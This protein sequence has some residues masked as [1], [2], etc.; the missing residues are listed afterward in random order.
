MKTSPFTVLS[1]ALVLALGY[2]TSSAESSLSSR[3]TIIVTTDPQPSSSPWSFGVIGD[4]QWTLEKDPAGKNPN[5]VS[6]SIINQINQQ[7]INKGVKFVIQVGDLTENGNDI[8]LEVRAKA[9]QAL[10]KA[11]IGFFPFRGNHETYA[12][13]DGSNG[14][15][16]AAFRS[17]FPQTRC[18]ANTFGATNCNSPSSVSS[19]LEGMSYSFDYGSKGNNARFVI[20]D[21][22]A[23]PSQ[24]IKA[25]KYLYGYSI[26]EQQ[27][28]I[29][30]R[31]DQ[32]SREAA[33]AFV[34][35]HQPPI[36]QNH[37]DSPFH[38]YTNANPEMQNAFIA[39]LQNNGVK[40]LITGHDHIHHRSI[41]AS[42][43]RLSK[44]QEQIIASASSKFYTPKTL[45][46]EKWFGQKMRE[47]SISQEL[48]SPGFY[49]YT[50]NGPRVTVDYYS[51]AAGG[52]KSD[53]AY[54]GTAGSTQGVTPKFNFEKKET[55]GYSLNGKEFLV[56]GNEKTSY[57]VV[58]DNFRNTSAGILSGEY[59]NEVVDYNGRT[60]TQAVT[61]GWTPG[62]TS[63]YSDIFSLW[64]MTPLG[65]NQ[66]S[67]YVLYIKYD[68]KKTHSGSAKAGGVGVA[69]PGSDGK[70][71]NAVAKNIGGTAK[72]VMGPWKPR[73]ELGAYGIDIKTSTAWAIINYNGAFAVAPGI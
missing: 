36:A 19:D 51:D 49:I 41:I 73:H 65:S 52:L 68:R 43:D 71:V 1:V 33:H 37:Q 24:Q 29:N 64:G 50:V 5:G 4:T 15:A 59:S 11:G 48:Y 17:N 53:G 10:Y 47:T 25:A 6:V 12:K 23:T 35:V 18:L 30:Q 26:A 58:Q 42:P 45:S 40:Y 66:T 39:S 8:D 28:W 67:T 46:D 13:P 9:A 22:W 21:Q 57:K 54:P 32:K 62:T 63:T 69:T 7:F 60:L 3:S 38:G 44:I 56:G 55:W 14:Y 61:T 2:G 31:L 16:I 34:F 20:V 70:W 27:P 72:F